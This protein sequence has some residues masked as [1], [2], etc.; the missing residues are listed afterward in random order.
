MGLA[1]HGTGAFKI[2]QGM[3]IAQLILERIVTNAEVVQGERFPS[4]S[5]GSSGLGS[6]GLTYLS[7]DSNIDE[8]EPISVMKTT[9]VIGGCSAAG[10]HQVPSQ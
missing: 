3:R 10:D 5:R 6:T 9:E 8:D 7:M 2:E 1:N 4:T